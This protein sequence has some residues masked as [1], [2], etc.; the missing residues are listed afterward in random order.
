VCVGCNK[1]INFFFRRGEITFPAKNL[2][3]ENV[4]FVYIEENLTVD[5]WC[6]SLVKL[7]LA[8]PK[9]IMI[10]NVKENVQWRQHV[11]TFQYIP[12]GGL[13]NF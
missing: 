13:N 2:C 3:L 7:A 1:S 4:V 6:V 9:Q 11:K 8:E 12:I 5:V 10:T